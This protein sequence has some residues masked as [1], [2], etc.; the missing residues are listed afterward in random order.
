MYLESTN[1]RWQ[2]KS[3]KASQKVQ[4]SGKAHT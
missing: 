4:K 3:L 2:S 1:Q